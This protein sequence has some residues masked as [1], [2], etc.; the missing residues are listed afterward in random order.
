[1]RKS[2]DFFL[3]FF[4]VGSGY[5][6]SIPSD[7]AV[8]L[9][10]K[11]QQPIGREKYIAVKKNGTITYTVDFKYIDRGSPVQLKDSMVFTTAMDPVY[12]RIRGGTSRFSKVNDSVAFHDP[13]KFQFP[14]DGYSPAT[15]QMLLIQYW[16]RKKSPKIIF[17]PPY[18]QVIV[19][20]AGEDTI[21][22]Q[23]KPEVFVRYIIKGLI[24][25]NE[26]LW[27]DQ[28]GVL[29]CLITNDAE[30]DKQ[31]MMLERY[32]SLLSVFIDKS[33]L[34]GMKLFA[35]EASANP[36]VKQLIAIRGGT[37]IDV[38]NSRALPDMTVLIENGEI[39]SVGKSGDIQVPAKAFVIEAKGKTILPGLWDM[40]AH[41][42]QAE[43][44]PAYLAAGVTT[45]RDCGNEF[46]YI[47]T[48]KETIDKGIGIGPDILKAGII[49][50]KGP[51]SLGIVQADTK[52]E[53]IAAVRLYKEN[54]FVQIKIY[55]SVKPHIV[56]TICRE[57]HRLNM[58]VTGHIPEGMNII[59]AV[60][61]GM[62]MVNHVNYVFRILKKGKDNDP[63]DFSDPEN[64][65]VMNFIKSR[66]IV[67]DPTLGVFELAFRSLK[68]SITLIEPD[69]STLPVPLQSLF[70]NTGMAN[71]K[72]IEWAK[73]M[74]NHFKQVVGQMYKDSITIVAGTDMGFPGYS[75]YRELEL[76][77]ECG[78]PPMA[79]IRT[80]TIVPAT[81]MKMSK[82]TG[83]VENGKRGDIILV[84]GNPLNDI[85]VIRKVSIVIRNGIVYKPTELHRM[86]GFQ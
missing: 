60:D 82:E 24:W 12:Y 26:L 56:A 27:T 75:V 59:Q 31:E 79:A 78:L 23:S 2:V 40:H 44:G 65:A 66:H 15:A 21:S 3:F 28:K 74:M 18:G 34:Y 54:G 71:E 67:I 68:D 36:Q 52:E 53:A 73:N 48:T 32:E 63:I 86:A 51:F 29:V 50:G 19:L 83:S 69:F 30:G 11:W 62:D 43:W 1:M 72:Q 46:G 5:A 8:Y 16:N 64:K 20:H 49:D 55:S 77:V 80:A 81:V 61:S 33:A 10:H 9:L 70:V 38:T 14:V 58:T 35:K 4:F 57:A 6:Q 85:S 13:K 41:F 47:N 42:E 7:S 45:V 39:K 25:G 37:L 17:T 76:Y 22:F 84:D